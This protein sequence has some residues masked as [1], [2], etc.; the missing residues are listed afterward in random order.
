[1]NSIILTGAG[2]I[3]AAVA[4]R[5]SLRDGIRVLLVGRRLRALEA[6][7]VTLYRPEVHAALSVD[8]SDARALVAALESERPGWTN[9]LVGVFANAGIEEEINGAMGCW[10]TSS[11]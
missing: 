2:G 7:R 5:L 6:V 1:M 11:G 8:V 10:K 9:P 3:G 4:Q